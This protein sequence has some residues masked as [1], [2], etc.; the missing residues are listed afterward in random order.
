MVSGDY[1]RW[2]A[3]YRAEQPP[4]DGDLYRAFLTADGVESELVFGDPPPAD[5][6]GAVAGRTRELLSRSDAAL[7]AYPLPPGRHYRP[8]VIEVHSAGPGRPRLAMGWYGAPESAP[9]VG[10]Q[11]FVDR[12]RKDIAQRLEGQ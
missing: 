8:A 6:P 3:R 2:V 1:V 12:A 5:D 4:A 7:A 11:A 10:W 9:R